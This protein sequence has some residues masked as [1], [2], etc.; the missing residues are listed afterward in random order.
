MGRADRCRGLVDCAGRQQDRG[1]GGIDVHAAEHVK[2]LYLA[3]S[4]SGGRPR[5]GDPPAI[6]GHR[7]GSGPEVAATTLAPEAVE[8]TGGMDTGQ[9]RQRNR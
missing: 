9:L 6:R 3:P 8:F 5:V 1:F 7:M 2:W 4:I